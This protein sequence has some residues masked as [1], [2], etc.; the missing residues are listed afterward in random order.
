MISQIAEI[1]SG[2]RHDIDEDGAWSEYWF[3][4]FIL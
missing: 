3:R 4:G 2:Q 1:G